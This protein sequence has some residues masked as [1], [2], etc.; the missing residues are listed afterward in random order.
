MSILQSTFLSLFLFASVFPAVAQDT[1]SATQAA[2]TQPTAAA[3]IPQEAP[4]AQLSQPAAVSMN[5][6]IDRVVQREH[7]FL[8]Q[9]RH[10]RPM[11]ETYLQ[12]L[13]DDKEGVTQPT[14]DQ[15]FLGRLDMSD[16]PEDTSFIGQPGFGHRMVNHLTGV[17]SMHFLPLG[18]A[19][20]V[21]LDTD[22]QRKY[23][24]F[25]FVRREFLGELR[26]LVI[27]VQPKKNAPPGRFLGR[28]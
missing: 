2:S 21:V 23:Y 18:F 28:I 9:M 12:Y 25:S 22:F 15:Y 13:K 3:D 14:K 17:Y 11:V 10:M 16:G 6:V 27:D 5:D 7:F 24:D 1:A 8:A 26:C 19:Q 20:M 4:S